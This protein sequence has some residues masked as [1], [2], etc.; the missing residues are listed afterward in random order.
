MSGQLRAIIGLVLMLLGHGHAHSQKVDHERELYTQAAAAIAD[1][2]PQDA[3]ASLNQIL[4]RYPE[5]SLASNAR[6][7]LAECYLVTSAPDRALRTLQGFRDD[8]DAAQ[9][10]QRIA[11]LT[12]IALRHAAA[13]AE[14][15]GDYLT[16]ITHLTSAIHAGAAN[17]GDRKALQKER[18]RVCLL[19]CEQ[20]YAKSGDTGQLL[21]SLKEFLPND[22][23]WIVMAKLALAERF[24]RSRRWDAAKQ[25]FESLAEL[26]R[27]QDAVVVSSAAAQIP[28][29]HVL[30]RLAEIHMELKEYTLALATLERA[31]QHLQDDRQRDTRDFL[32]ARCAIAT[33]DFVEAKERLGRIIARYSE[34]LTEDRKPPSV[35]KPSNSDREHLARALWM[36]GE[37]EF[38]Q[39]QYA[40]AIESY[41]AAENTGDPQW[42]WNARL[43]RAKCLELQGQSDAARELYRSVASQSTVPEVGQ[44][45]RKRMAALP[46]SP[47]LQR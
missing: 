6:L 41:R 3:I 11:Q 38:M 4:E 34:P 24:Y 8:Q 9:F 26:A 5:S 30:L 1:A 43:Q 27:Q 7:H 39:K 47:S 46:S 23:E 42:I 20:E 14:Q 36:T 31:E 37:I 25:H 44:F 16:A 40:V 18:V 12:N 28:K 19:A 21:D 35:Q 45:A 33:I 17:D 13:E 22:N 32:A 10:Q 29:G 2:R 15:H